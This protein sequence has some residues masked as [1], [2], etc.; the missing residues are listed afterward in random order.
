V[1]NAKHQVSRPAA[2]AAPADITINAKPTDP[3]GVTTVS[4]VAVHAA[5]T[6]LRYGR[7]V[8]QNAFG[9]ETETLAMP[10]TVQ[11]Y[12]GTTF[13]TNDLDPCT[14]LSVLPASP[15]QW[16]NILLPPASYTDNL[17]A[18]ETAPTYTSFADGT[19]VIILSAPGLGNEG[20]VGVTIDLTGAGLPWLQY[21]WD[22]P[23]GLAGPYDDNPS[24]IATFGIYRGNDRFINWREIMR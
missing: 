18:G 12:D 1:V 17:E 21:D 9:P 24:A 6:A 23:D 15:P 16:G 14:T 7:L 8:L 4:A 3:D 5:T 11:Y 13:Q 22:D 10:L 20:N 2:P 19:G